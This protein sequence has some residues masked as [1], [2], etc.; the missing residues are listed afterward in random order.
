MPVCRKW[1]WYTVVLESSTPS[2]PA[3]TMECE[4]YSEQDALDRIVISYKMLGG[5]MIHLTGEA[6]IFKGRKQH[7][8]FSTTED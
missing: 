6:Y 7:L 4:G 1:E 8:T 2:P 3:I 5:K